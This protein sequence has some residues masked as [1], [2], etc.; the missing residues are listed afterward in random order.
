MTKSPPAVDPQCPDGPE[1][2]PFPSWPYAWEKAFTLSDGLP[3]A[4]SAADAPS[5]TASPADAM[6]AWRAI[7][8]APYTAVWSAYAR[9]FQAWAA[10][11]VVEGAVE[12]PP[13]A[14]KAKASRPKRASL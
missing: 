7:V 4:K 10:M 12:A 14:P 5:A 8:M 6:D 13:A 11:W 9:G 1:P 3:T 2:H